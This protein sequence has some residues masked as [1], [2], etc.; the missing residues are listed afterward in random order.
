[1]NEIYDLCNT[2]GIDYNSFRKKFVWEGNNAWV[3]DQHT[4]VPGPDG[5]KGFGGKCLPKDISGLKTAF[6]KAD[7][8]S[9]VIDSTILANPSRRK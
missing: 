6:I 2:I 8:K 1:M 3:C 7:I 4:Y 5:K 9:P